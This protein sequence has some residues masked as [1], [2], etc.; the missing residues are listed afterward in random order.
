[1]GLTQAFS[2]SEDNKL[3]VLDGVD[4]AMVAFTYTRTR[5]ANSAKAVNNPKLNDVSLKFCA[6]TEEINYPVVLLT[7]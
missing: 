6:K 7:R 4:G 3:F 5:L 1:M 2:P